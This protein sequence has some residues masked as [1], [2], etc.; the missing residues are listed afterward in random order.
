MA[1]YHVHPCGGLV[2]A[3]S[4]DP[5][6]P[7]IFFCSRCGASFTFARVIDEVVDGPS[8]EALVETQGICL[9]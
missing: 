9:L 1:L 5:K 7:R 2:E 4:S 6:N 8:F 3:G